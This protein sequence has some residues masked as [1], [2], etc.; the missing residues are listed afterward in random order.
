MK[1]FSMGS[2]AKHKILAGS[3]VLLASFWKRGKCTGV[4]SDHTR[5]NDGKGVRYETLRSCEARLGITATVFP[6][7]LVSDDILR[8]FYKP[9]KP[10]NKNQKCDFCNRMFERKLL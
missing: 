7:R 6:M 3:H 9:I 4:L 2:R 5:R 10:E 8:D 1:T